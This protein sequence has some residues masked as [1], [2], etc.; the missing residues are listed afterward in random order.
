MCWVSVSMPI[1]T[2]FEVEGLF[3]TVI[4]RVGELQA[5]EFIHGVIDL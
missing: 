2:P 4:P 1:V 3:Q 5:P